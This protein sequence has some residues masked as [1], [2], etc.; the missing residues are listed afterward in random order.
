MLACLPTLLLQFFCAAPCASQNVIPAV[1]QKELARDPRQQTS[2]DYVHC[3]F[4][5]RVGVIPDNPADCHHKNDWQRIAANAGACQRVRLAD[6][7]EPF[8]FAHDKAPIYPVNDSEHG[9]VR[10]AEADSK[11]RSVSSCMEKTK[12]LCLFSSFESNGAPTMEAVRNR[13]AFKS[14]QKGDKRRR[15][16]EIVSRLGETATSSQ[17]RQEAYRVGYGV[18]SSAS[19]VAARN[20]LWPT[21]VKKNNGKSYHTVPPTPYFVDGV[22]AEYVVRQMPRCPLCNHDKP[23]THRTHKNS[24]GVVISRQLRCRNCKHAFNGPGGASLQEQRR[25]AARHATQKVCSTCKALRDINEFGL[26]KSDNDLRRSSC[27][28]CLNAKRAKRD[29]ITTVEK[30]GITLQEYEHIL[31]K[32]QRKCAV[33]GSEGRGK[34][35]RHKPLCVDHCHITGKFRG[36]LCNKCNLGVGNF[37]DDI[38]RLLNMVAYLREFNS[39]QTNS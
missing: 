8:C 38:D 22:K 30:Y 13:E 19:L 27:R 18:I 29:I 17:I 23:E 21:R 12:S 34:G 6:F 10:V 3:L 14:I 7:T 32:Q 25:L 2:G 5:F 11:S 20:S 33:C 9:C 26:M 15:L 4:H 24:D 35:S 37:N 31:E 1:F 28:S 36:L 39:R 16:V